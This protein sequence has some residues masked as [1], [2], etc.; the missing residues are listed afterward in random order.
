MNKLPKMTIFRANQEWQWRN[1]V[2]T[3]V[4]WNLTCTLHLS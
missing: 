4:K 1:I 2:F 3:I